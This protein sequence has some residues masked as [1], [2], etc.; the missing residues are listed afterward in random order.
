MNKNTHPPLLVWIILIF[1]GTLACIA[2]CKAL[3]LANQ[4]TEYIKYPAV[5]LLIGIPLSTLGAF[6]WCA[7]MAYKLQQQ[8]LEFQHFQHLELNQK[9]AQFL[10]GQMLGASPAMDQDRLDAAK[11]LLQ[12]AQETNA[13]AQ[14][15]R[16]EKLD[17]AVRQIKELLEKQA[18]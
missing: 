18:K 1:S 6:A 11:A 3:A 9:A 17:A 2:L 10:E 13:S 8:K 4:S 5:L 15:V 14:K 16:N 7:W 12:K